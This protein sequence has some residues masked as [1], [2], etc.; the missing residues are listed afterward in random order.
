MVHCLC[1]K[2]DN[3]YLMIQ[4][5]KKRKKKKKK[6]TQRSSSGTIRDSVAEIESNAL[7]RRKRFHQE[8][9]HPLPHLK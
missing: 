7:I 1:S 3:A 9:P 8:T 5:A 6:K 4:N 2:Q